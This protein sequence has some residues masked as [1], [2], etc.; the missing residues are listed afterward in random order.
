MSNNRFVFAAVSL[1]VFFVDFAAAD[2]VHDL[3]GPPRRRAE[4]F[5]IRRLP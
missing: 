5:D 3:R 4:V 1:M 2:D